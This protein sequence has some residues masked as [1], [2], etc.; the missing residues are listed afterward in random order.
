MNMHVP[1]SIMCREELKRIALVPTQ[2]IS[3]GDSKPCTP[4]VQDSIIGAYL[5]TRE[6]NKFTKAQIQSLMMFYDK[7]DNIFPE[8]AG[9]NE[10]GEEY[11]DGKQVFSMILPKITIKTESIQVKKGKI[12]DGYLQKDSLESDTAGFIQQIYNAFGTD[13]ATNF[14]NNTQDLITKFM[15]W[16]SFSIGYG[17]CIPAKETSDENHILLDDAI[18]KAENTIRQ[19]QEGV[20]APT[21][22]KRLLKALIIPL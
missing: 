20:Y 2:L 19:A 22:D 11:W 14:L 4:I 17:D 16:N 3:P 5:M 8:P 9:T 13:E 12:V 7:F 18:N 15:V 10:Y 21:L 1:Q 6:D